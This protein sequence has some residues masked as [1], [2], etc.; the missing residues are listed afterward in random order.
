VSV[1]IE[2]E[3]T[4][5]LTPR[6]AAPAGVVNV[7]LS[8]SDLDVSFYDGIGVEVADIIWEQ[9]AVALPVKLLC[10]EECRGVCPVCGANRN[11]EP[12]RCP[13]A[14]RRGAFEALRTLR[15]RKE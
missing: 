6:D 7:E 5:V 15:D 2:R 12:C 8:G 11:T 13:A 3:F 14:D 9:V 4:S 1:R 10:Q